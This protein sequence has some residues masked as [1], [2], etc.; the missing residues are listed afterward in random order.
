MPKQRSSQ[1]WGGNAITTK[2]FL[3]KKMALCVEKNVHWVT[4]FSGCQRGETWHQRDQWKLTQK[5][6]FGVFLKRWGGWYW[7][8]NWK[9]T[10]N[11]QRKNVIKTPPRGEQNHTAMKT[12]NK[13][14]NLQHTWAHLGWVFE[15]FWK[16]HKFDQVSKNTIAVL[17][18]TKNNIMRTS[19]YRTYHI[20]YVNLPRGWTK[21]KRG[22]GVKTRGGGFFF[23]LSCCC[24]FDHF[25]PQD[26]HILLHH[27]FTIVSSNQYS[28]EHHHGITSPSISVL[29]LIHPKPP[30][31]MSP[32][33]LLAG[34]L[35][36]S[37]LRSL[38]VKSLL[39]HTQWAGRSC[40]DPSSGCCTVLF[41]L[42]W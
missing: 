4:F 14:D 34:D 21:K 35:Y 2:F 23:L 37:H 25:H 30:F 40:L 17:E 12:H 9:K 15:Y 39:I 27:S 13:T 6:R 16:R 7:W 22:E 32:P 8:G 5:S 24:L 28:P 31:A 29:K 11:G 36:Q 38:Q 19:T 42:G 26:D 1:W 18:M 10:K 33:F 20:E 41:I 3:Q